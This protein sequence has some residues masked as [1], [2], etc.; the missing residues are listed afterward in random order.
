VTCIVNGC[1]QVAEARRLCMRHYHA[2]RDAG[3]L[4]SYPRCYW[5]RGTRPC[6]VEGCT[7]SVAGGGRGWCPMHYRRWSVAQRQRLGSF[8][9]S[10]C[11]RVFANSR[12]LREHRGK[13]HDIRQSRSEVGRRY[14]RTHKEVYRR[15]GLE[16][17]A[18]ETGASG[19]CTK[20]Q[21]AAR[22]HVFGA[23]CWMCGAPWEHW[24][25]VIP[26]A[27]GGTNWPANL[28]PACASCNQRKNASSVL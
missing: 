6:S 5:G 8:L 22:L 24:D 10:E 12:A 15:N 19:H 4:D 9:C 20:E 2:A 1:T 16:R 21:L 14:Y 3:T 28:R 11:P 13:M 7:K 27:R 26:L 25:H 23:R 18:R 17:R